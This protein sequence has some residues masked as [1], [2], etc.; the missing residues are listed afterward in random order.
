MHRIDEVRPSSP[1]PGRP[2]SRPAED[3]AA[4]SQQAAARFQHETLF[5]AGPHEF[6]AGTLPFI[7][8]ALERREPVLVAVVP[9]RQ[10]LLRGALG[11]GAAQVQFLDMH[12]L[13]RNPARIIPAWRAFLDSS[14][15]GGQPVRGIGEPIWAGRSEAEL[16]ECERHESLVNV[17]F[18]GGR[19]WRLLCPYDT[20]GLDEGVIQGAQRTH[21]LIARDGASHSS[22]QFLAAHAAPSPFAG[23]LPAPSAPFEQRPFDICDLG[24]VRDSVARWAEAAG[25]GPERT[26]DL[27]LAV[28]ELASNSVR[29]GGGE[30]ILRVWREPRALL[31]EVIDTGRI[32]QPLTGRIAPTPAQHRG[33]GL[34]LVN[35]VCDLVQIRSDDAGTVVRVQMETG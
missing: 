3:Y 17:A 13:G 35:Q 31:C 6:L 10:W 7:E 2:S 15:A 25:L 16:C 5:Y 26:S 23:S 12:V 27:V 29:H 1:T 30:G 22:E 34:W 32:E 24:S 33:R 18:D 20:E 14:G 21:P 19:P 8:G 28:C 11:A 4:P 9:E